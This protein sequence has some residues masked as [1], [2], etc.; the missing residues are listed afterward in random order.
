MLRLPCFTGGLALHCQSSHRVAPATGLLN[1]PHLIDCVL[2]SVHL[3]GASFICSQ[4]LVALAMCVWHTM[5]AFTIRLYSY[6][7]GSRVYVGVQ[8]YRVVKPDLCFPFSLEQC[9]RINSF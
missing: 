7:C 8:Q 1:P 5:F 4:I 3:D 6:A 2:D 9:L